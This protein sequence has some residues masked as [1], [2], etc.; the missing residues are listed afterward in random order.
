M[1]FTASSDSLIST[2]GSA[3][4]SA[5]ASSSSPVGQAFFGHGSG[6]FTWTNSNTA[7]GLPSS[8]SGQ[9]ASWT[10]PANTTSSAIV[11]NIT[12]SA[13]LNGCPIV[14]DVFSVTIN[15]TPDYVYTLN[16]INGFSC[17]STTITIN[18]TV[19]IPN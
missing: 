18:G 9:I 4:S 13:Q 7:I 10:A 15:P 6:T 5:G 12:I 16:P 3:G 19:S 8:G 17:I 14:Q 11:G 1:R 2:T